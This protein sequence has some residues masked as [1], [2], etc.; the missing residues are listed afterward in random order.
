MKKYDETS[1][2]SIKNYADKLVG[3]TFYDVL[4]SYFSET[5]LEENNVSKDENIRGEILT[6]ESAKYNPKNKELN[7]KVKYY[8]NPRAKGGLGNLIERYYF[9]YEPNNN[10]GPDFPEAGVEL[11]V[12]PYEIN[13]NGKFRAGERL[14]ISMI[15]NNE[16]IS[17]NFYKSSLFCKMNLMLLILYLRNRDIPRINYE[18]DYVKLFSILSEQCK[19][20]LKIIEDDYRV[21]VGK[22]R[23]GKAEELSESDTRYLG[24]CTKGA[25]AKSSLQPQYYSDTLAKR[26]AFSLKQSYMTYVINHYIKN[27]ICTYD[28]VINSEELTSVNF[29]ELILNKINTYLGKTESNIYRQFNI[30][31]TTKQKNNLAICRI[32]GVKT[33]RIAEFEKANIKIKTIRVKR[34]GKPKESMSFPAFKIKEVIRQTFEESALYQDFSETRFLLVV[35][36]ENNIGDFVLTGAKFW[37]MPIMEL[38]TTGKKEWEMYKQKF[39]DGVHFQIT[40]NQIMNDLPKSKDTKIFHIRPHA[41]NSAYVI[42][43]E[44][45]GKGTYSDMDELPNGDMMTKQC[46]WLNYDYVAEVINKLK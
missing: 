8:N 6:S 23:E 11:K 37:N 40:S 22:I 34:N 33:D 20:D 14:V 10:S 25:T 7:K 16:P 12:I 3:N 46:F 41:R 32:L 18:I 17:D 35:F 39:I 42:E 2:E 13:K 26:R 4:E 29:D 24:A 1:I 31:S 27:D 21:I 9:L 38:E 36:K 30:A 15:P 19:N 44:K 45:Y 5:L 28:S 43:G